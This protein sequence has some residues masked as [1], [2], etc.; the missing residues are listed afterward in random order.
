M[1][2][3]H[4]QTPEAKAAA[5]AKR[6]AF[7]NFANQIAKMKPEDRIAM[8][9]QSPITTINLQ[10]LS[11]KNQCLIALQM[12]TATICAGFRQ[13]LKNGRAVMKG[14]KALSIWIPTGCQ[15]SDGTGDDAGGDANETRFVVGS[16]FD[17]Q[18]TEE[19]AEVTQ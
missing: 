12:P 14:Q 18:Q 2:K 8:A 15:K 6:A 17:I 19:I 1:S 13:W 7:K 5:E 9:M 16:V 4:E 11:V 10:P 3:R